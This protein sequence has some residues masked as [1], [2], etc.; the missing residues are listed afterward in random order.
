M[1]LTEQSQDNPYNT[2]WSAILSAYYM[3]TINL[4]TYNYWPLK[5]FALIANIIIVLILINMIIALMK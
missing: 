4:N 5:L 1:T 3:S 2:I